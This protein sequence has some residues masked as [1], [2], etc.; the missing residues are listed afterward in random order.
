MYCLFQTHVNSIT[1]DGMTYWHFCSPWNVPDEELQILK[2]QV[3]SSV[4]VKPGFAGSFSRFYEIGNCSISVSRVAGGI[5][6]GIKLYSVTSA[7]CR[8]ACH[9]G[10]RIDEDRCPYSFFLECLAYICEEF[11]MFDTI[12]SWIWCYGILGIRY[13]SNLI[14][15]NFQDKVYEGGDRI[16]FNIEF[17][18][19]LTFNIEWS[20]LLGSALRILRLSWTNINLMYLG[21]DLN[22]NEHGFLKYFDLFLVIFFSSLTRGSETG[23]PLHFL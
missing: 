7:F 6:F 19:N 15:D 13:Q 21:G 8:R 17:C 10:N 14:R 4:D 16:A 23:R 11:L 20:F 22:T 3:M 9:S 18:S 12:P 2:A 5:W 1:N